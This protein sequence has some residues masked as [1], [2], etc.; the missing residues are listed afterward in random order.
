MPV[1]PGDWT[2]PSCGDHQFARNPT[3]RKCGAQQPRAGCM[4]TARASQ[5]VQE[6]TG[7][8]FAP[9]AH[10]SRDQ[11]PQPGDW[12]CNFCNDLQFARNTQCRRCGKRRV[13]VEVSVP[14]AAAM[15]SLP[16]P[17]SNN[18]QQPQHGDWICAGCGDLQFA[19]N[20][21]CRQCGT[22]RD[23]Q[24]TNQTLMMPAAVPEQTAQPRITA[25]PGDWVCPGCQDLQFQRNETCRC[26]G[27]PKPTA[28][29]ASSG[30]RHMDKGKGQLED[31]EAW[32]GDWYCNDCGDLQF[33]RNSTCRRCGAPSPSVAAQKGVQV[34]RQPNAASRPRPTSRYDVEPEAPAPETGGA[35]RAGGGSN[36]R[37]SWVC[38]SCHSLGKPSDNFCSNC[39]SAR[40]AL[41]GHKRQ[42]GGPAGPRV[43]KMMKVDPLDDVDAIY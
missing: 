32:P 37:A 17:V 36:R 3:C 29:S 28:R 34:L 43:T 27:T 18:K 41:E 26:C 8:A 20:T 13:G 16:L 23:V 5:T 10:Q 1:L 22:P 19:R 6:G 7:G 42:A 15:P 4:G 35:G 40:P 14:A 21:A 38:S 31:S 9:L 11:T 25:M 2:C 33:A 39:G 12:Y 30:K 24:T